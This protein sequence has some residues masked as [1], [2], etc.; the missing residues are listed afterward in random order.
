MDRIEIFIR[1]RNLIW[2]KWKGSDQIGRFRQDRSGSHRRIGSDL[3]ESKDRDKSD[4]TRFIGL[5][6]SSLI[7]PDIDESEPNGPDLSGFEMLSFEISFSEHQLTIKTIDYYDD[8]DDNEIDETNELFSTL[9]NLLEE[10]K[11]LLEVDSKSEEAK[12]KLGLILELDE[13]HQR[14]EGLE[15]AK[16]LIGISSKGK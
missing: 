11:A 15:A 5:K 12:E 13:D 10:A 1:L 2:K 6:G 9:F 16:L 4:R 7:G 14:S 3:N 8:Y